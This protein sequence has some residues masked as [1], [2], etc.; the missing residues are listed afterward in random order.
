MTRYSKKEW[1]HKKVMAL[2]NVHK[3]HGYFVTIGTQ[4]AI[5]LG[6]GHY[7]ILLD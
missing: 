2:S 4:V 1:A 3:Y 5:T 7:L 6:L